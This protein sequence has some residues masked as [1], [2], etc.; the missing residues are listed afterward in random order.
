MSGVDPEFIVHRLNVDPYIPPRSKAKTF[1]QSSRGSH[2][3]GSEEAKASWSYLK[4]VL[5][6]L[7]VQ[8]CGD[9]KEEWEMEGLR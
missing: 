2:E 1:S 3:G 9:E 6:G 7:V 5:P 8:Y 4:S